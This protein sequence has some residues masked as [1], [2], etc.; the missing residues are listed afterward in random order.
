M[1]DYQ[2]GDRPVPTGSVVRYENRKY[3]VIEHRK[4]TSHPRLPPGKYKLSEV[5]PDDVAYVL[6]PHNLPK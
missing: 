6:W 4:P 2:P 3:E 1:H 5:Y